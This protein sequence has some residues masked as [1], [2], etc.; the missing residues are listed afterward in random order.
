M[1]LKSEDATEAELAEAFQKIGALIVAASQLDVS[2]SKLIAAMAEM[3]QNPAADM[4]IHSID[5]SR[6][7]QIIESYCSMFDGNGLDAPLD[8]LAKFSEHL[9]P[10]IDDRNTAAHGLLKRHDGK[11]CVTGYAAVRRFRNTGKELRDEHPTH[12]SI[13][14]FDSKIAR[15][16]R[17]D[18]EAMLL[19]RLF[20]A[21]HTKTEINGDKP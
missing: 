6:K 7:R 15:C 20:A 4:L 13:D 5:L 18:K 10:V 12:I 14:S 3:A 19:T 8:R 9:R 16:S 1:A 17:L 2:I 11:L 21:L